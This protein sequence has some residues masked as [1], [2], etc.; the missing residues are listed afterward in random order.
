MSLFDLTDKS[1]EPTIKD[2]E[3]AFIEQRN[4]FQQKVSAERIKAIER[5]FVDMSLRDRNESCAKALTPEERIIYAD[6]LEN[7]KG[8]IQSAN[9]F[10]N[11]VQ[12][13]E[14]V[15]RGKKK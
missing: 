2:G 15:K 1:I 5:K 9:A 14:K 8:Q 12:P 7:V 11:Y 3:T 10:R 13:I 6:Y 4:A